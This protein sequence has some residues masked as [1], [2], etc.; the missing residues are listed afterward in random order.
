MGHSV[1]LSLSVLNNVSFN[2]YFAQLFKHTAKWRISTALFLLN[3]SS[4]V[5]Y[6]DRAVDCLLRGKDSAVPKSE[7]CSSVVC[8]VVAKLALK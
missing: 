4:N 1:V 6:S 2:V 5:L 7:L 8:A 3:F